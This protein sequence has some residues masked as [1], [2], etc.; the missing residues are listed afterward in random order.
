MKTTLLLTFIFAW[1]SCVV[2]ASREAPTDRVVINRYSGNYTDQAQRDAVSRLPG[3]GDVGFGIYSGRTNARVLY[4]WR[5][6]CSKFLLYDFHE[7]QLFC[8]RLVTRAPFKNGDSA[9]LCSGTSCM[10]KGCLLVCVLL[11][12]CYPNACSATIASPSLAVL[13]QGTSTLTRMLAG[14]CSTCSSRP[15]RTRRLLRLSCG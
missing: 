10:C 11:L 13:F 3:W 4:Q 2:S 5:F 15:R 12:P 6:P 7:M 8:L 9:Q 14:S 1:L